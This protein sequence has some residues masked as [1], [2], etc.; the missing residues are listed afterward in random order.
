M[1]VLHAVGA[2]WRPDTRV[3][4]AFDAFVLSET[5]VLES[6]GASGLPETCV[7]EVFGAPRSLFRKYCKDNA[8]SRGI[9]L[10]RSQFA[11]YF[12]GRF[13]VLAPLRCAENSRLP[14]MFCASCLQ[15]EF[16]VFAYAFLQFKLQSPCNFAYFSGGKTA[17][18][19]T[20]F[21][22]LHALAL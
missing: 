5:Y 1:R 4:H 13:C 7:V 6:F 8:F 19:C 9:R 18:R 11:A 12:L 14:R 17:V 3:S 15:C 20:L 22:R 16:C 2:S 10:V 21:R